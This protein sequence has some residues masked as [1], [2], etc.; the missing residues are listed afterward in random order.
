MQNVSLVFDQILDLPASD[1]IFFKV[2]IYRDI[3][4][5][6]FSSQ[7]LV[8]F[9]LA[10]SSSRDSLSKLLGVLLRYIVC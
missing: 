5:C 1:E 8:M 7:K 9:H 4:M 10:L 6:T 2:T 3:L